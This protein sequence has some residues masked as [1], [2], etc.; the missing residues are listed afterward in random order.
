MQSDSPVKRILADQLLDMR[1]AADAL[2]IPAQMEIW[3]PAADDEVHILKP[4]TQAIKIITDELTESTGTCN[5]YLPGVAHSR[6]QELY[7]VAYDT[8]GTTIGGVNVYANSRKSGAIDGDMLDLAGHLGLGYGYWDNPFVMVP[9][10]IIVTADGV[11]GL[12]DIAYMKN[13]GFGWLL[14]TIGYPISGQFPEF[15]Q[16]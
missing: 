16:I 15:P 14:V 1:Q 2:T 13:T 3:T 9:G 4:G 8:D 10:A 6:F 12:Y 11:G 5:L 7:I